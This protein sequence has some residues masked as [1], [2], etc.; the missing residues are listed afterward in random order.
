MMSGNG[1][2]ATGSAS[3]RSGRRTIPLRKRWRAGGFSG[4]CRPN[5]SRSPREPVLVTHLPNAL[6]GLNVEVAE[7]SPG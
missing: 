6:D 2:S 7:A 4:D 3:S 5:A 1:R